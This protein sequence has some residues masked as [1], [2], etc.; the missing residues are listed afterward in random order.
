[1]YPEGSTFGYELS[2]FFGGGLKIRNILGRNLFLFTMAIL[3]ELFEV[4]DNG[5][6]N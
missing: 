6:S 2:I 5:S 3:Q 1:M 4:F